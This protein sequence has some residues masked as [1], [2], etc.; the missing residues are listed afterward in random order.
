MPTNNR[1]EREMLST[2]ETIKAAI[3]SLR[4][5]PT[6][7]PEETETK[8]KAYSLFLQAMTP[9]AKFE[10]VGSWLWATYEARPPRETLNALKDLGFYWN[11]VR[12]IWQFAAHG[13]RR[14]SRETTNELRTRIGARPLNGGDVRQYPHA[15]VSPMVAD[16]FSMRGLPNV[17]VRE[18]VE[19]GEEI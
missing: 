3:I 4:A 13:F 6:T 7:N 9:S 15:T 8:L 18:S 12:S 17:S 16:A 19:T 14:R 11:R 1:S 10:L 2:D 5:M